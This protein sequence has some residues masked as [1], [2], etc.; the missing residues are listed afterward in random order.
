[1]LIFCF[2]TFSLSACLSLQF[3]LLKWLVYCFIN[4]GFFFKEKGSTAGLFGPFQVVDF[5]SLPSPRVPDSMDVADDWPRRLRRLPPR[6]RRP[7]VR[8]GSRAVPQV[9]EVQVHDV[10][11][12]LGAARRARAAGGAAPRRAERVPRPRRERLHDL[13]SRKGPRQLARPRSASPR[14]AVPSSGRRRRHA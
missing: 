7:A 8:P 14:P 12:L 3:F 13:R 5:D 10:G 1:M 11:D 4:L 2:S 6:A 9:H